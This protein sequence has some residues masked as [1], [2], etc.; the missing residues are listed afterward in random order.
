MNK[1]T[2]PYTQLVQ[3]ALH[4]LAEST[5]I[6]GHWTEAGGHFDGLIT[7]DIEKKSLDYPVV[8]KPKVDREVAVKTIFRPGFQRKGSLLVTSRLSDEMANRCRELG[9]QF[10]DA[11]GNAFIKDGKNIFVFVSGRKEKNI[12]LTKQGEAVTTPAALRA[13]FVILVRTDLLNA[14]LRETAMAARISI[15]SAAQTFTSL[16]HRGFLGV[17]GSGKNAILDRQRLV[18]EWASGYINR[19]RPKLTKMRFQIPRLPAMSEGVLPSGAAW[20]GEAAASILTKHFKPA[21]FTIYA[22]MQDGQVMTKLIKQLQ[23]RPD[24]NGPLEIIE[25]FWE[26]FVLDVR[27]VVPPELAFAD[28]LASL[29]PRNVEVADLIQRTLIANA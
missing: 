21:R 22:D 17:D 4:K 26:P 10:I 1:A 27:D 7:L 11:A 29:E 24:P 19:L 18:L 14:T 12:P 3:Q 2:S 8:I 16:H 9:V 15:G 28:L 5:G 6:Q 23:L 13:I 25:T 20:G